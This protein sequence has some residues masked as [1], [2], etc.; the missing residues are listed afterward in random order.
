MNR[1]DIQNIRV[2]KDLDSKLLKY[3]G[4]I[5]VDVDIKEVK[6]QK[7][8]K[9]GIT[10]YVEKKLPKEELSTEET[11]PAEI[12]GIPT[13]VVECLNVWPSSEASAQAQVY[14]L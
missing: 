4:A 1:E 8:D 9:F 12:E 11:I 14:L 5:G 7:T 13:D 3:K 10:I 2:E 6:S